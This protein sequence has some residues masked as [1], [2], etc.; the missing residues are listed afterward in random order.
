LKIE[1]N[2]NIIVIFESIKDVLRHYV[3]SY[4]MINHSY[5]NFKEKT[6]LEKCLINFFFTFNFVWM[7]GLTINV[8]QVL[9][10][11]WMKVEYLEI[12]ELKMLMY[13]HK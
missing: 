11:I 4:I 6:F 3:S 7:E 13:K 2:K 1:R 9:M 12:K 8:M 10:E 5:I